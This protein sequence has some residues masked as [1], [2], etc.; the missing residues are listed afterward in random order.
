MEKAYETLEAAQILADGQQ[1][2]SAI[3]RLYYACFYAVTALLTEA[4]I[5]TRSHS[6]AKSQFFL[7]FVKNKKVDAKFGR[8]YSDLFDWRQK[9]DYGDFFDFSNQDVTPLLFPCQQMI[10]HIST[11]LRKKD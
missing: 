6:G 11:I 10:D 9:G 5:E 1:W 2:N 8:L 3:N 4:R 7:P